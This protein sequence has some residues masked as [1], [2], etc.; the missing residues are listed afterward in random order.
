VLLRANENDIRM[1]V[2]ITNSTGYSVFLLLLLISL[3]NRQNLTTPQILTYD[4][5]AAMVGDTRDST[6]HG[7]HCSN[8]SPLV[9]FWVIY[10]C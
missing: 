6:T 2:H 5:H 4:K 10:L 9:G 7:G 1:T 8:A 3:S